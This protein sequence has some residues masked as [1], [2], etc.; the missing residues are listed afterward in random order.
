MLWI[1]YHLVPGTSSWSGV[2]VTEVTLPLFYILSSGSLQTPSCAP[3]LVAPRGRC[4]VALRAHFQP[5]A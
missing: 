5:W 3:P 1:T 4:C 2:E